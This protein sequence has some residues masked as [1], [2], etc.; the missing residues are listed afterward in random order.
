[1]AVE[2][3][4]EEGEGQGAENKKESDDTAGF[5]CREKNAF[6]LKY[7]MSKIK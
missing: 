5:A 3:E 2:K 4:R 6:S 1:M 7:N